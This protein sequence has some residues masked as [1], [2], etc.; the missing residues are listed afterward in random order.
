MIETIQAFLDRRNAALPAHIRSTRQQKHRDEESQGEFESMGI[1]FTHDDIIML[2]GDPG[3]ISPIIEKET[4]FCDVSPY[5]PSGNLTD[6]DAIQIIIDH[7][8]P[9]IYKLLSNTFS[10]GDLLQTDAVDVA[11]TQS[12]ISK[13]AK[14][15]A[16]CAS[17]LVVDHHRRVRCDRI[18]V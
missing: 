12:W 13:L 1:D 5:P 7:I 9:G 2:G 18:P 15:W 4:A 14:C 11:D 3:E 8:S 6:Q 10:G 16:D 17:V